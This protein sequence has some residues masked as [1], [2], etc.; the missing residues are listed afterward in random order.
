MEAPSRIS[1][2]HLPDCHP[3]VGNNVMRKLDGGLDF[4][5]IRLE[6]LTRIPKPPRVLGERSCFPEQGLE[7]GLVLQAGERQLTDVM[8]SAEEMVVMGE[9][10]L[11]RLLYRLL[12]VE[13]RVPEE[14]RA[15]GQIHFR[16]SQVELGTRQPRRHVLC[17]SVKLHATARLP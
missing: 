7:R 14:G 8:R 17:A 10:R 11:Q 5:P 16:C 2:G 4:V 6:D 15:R 9:K 12:T 3:H 1:D 13:R